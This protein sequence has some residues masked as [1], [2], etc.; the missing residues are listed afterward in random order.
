MSG[1]LHWDYAEPS[2]E[3]ERRVLAVPMA[4]CTGASPGPN[5]LPFL[6]VG[7]FFIRATMVSS[8]NVGEVRGEYLSECNVNGIPGP[9]P[10]PGPGPYRIQLY[11][12][13]LSI[14][15]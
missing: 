13:P 8:G 10:G 5:D 3:L 7:C 14:D 1:V 2:G 11:K 6:K 4:D 12:D 15:S 9:S